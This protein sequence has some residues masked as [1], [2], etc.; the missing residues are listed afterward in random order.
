[1]MM[2][3]GEYQFSVDK[4]A[5]QSWQRSTSWRWVRQERVG[6]QASWQYTGPGEDNLSLDGV[7][8]PYYRGG[9]GQIDKM[10]DE[11]NKATPLVLID[12]LGNVLGRWVIKSISETKADMLRDGTSQRVEFTIELSLAGK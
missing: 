6:A 11:A 1:M 7:I 5:Y 9:L 4:A 12:G 8:Y 10:R 3:L 2:T